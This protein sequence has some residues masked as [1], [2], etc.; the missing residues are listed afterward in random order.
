M[1]EKQTGQKS[2]NNNSLLWLSI[3]ILVSLVASYF[4]FPGFKA[5]VN[6]AFDVLTSEDDDRIRTWVKQF[7]ALGP[8]VLILSMTAQMFMLIIPNLLLFIIAILCYGPIWGSLICLAGVFTSSTIGYFVGKKLGP[9]A[10]DRFVS[11]KMQEKISAFV[12]RYGVKAIAI[13]RLSSLAS[14][15]LGFVAGILEMEYKK[16]IIA[17]MTGILPVVVLIAIFGKN[18]NVE[19]SLLWIAGIA[20]VLLIIYIILD[21]RKHGDKPTSNTHPS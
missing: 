5:G 8:I 18:G 7:G 16:F 17:T 15:A 9:R 14:D 19:K 6:E 10:I 21:R 13:A 2:K 12:G 4:I 1:G 3:A 20:V 11:E